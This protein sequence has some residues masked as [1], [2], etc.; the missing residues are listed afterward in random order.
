MITQFKILFGFFILNIVAFSAMNATTGAGE[1]LIPGVQYAQGIEATANLTQTEQQF[2]ATAMIDEW[3][4]S[5]EIGIPLFGDIYFVAISFAKK[6]RFLFDG[7]AMTLEWFGGFIPSTGG[8]A[9]LSFITLIIRGALAVMVGTLI[10]E[11][12]SGRRL[13]P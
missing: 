3:D 7:F 5:P 4:T 11:I 8:Q 9:A 6:M 12:I 13:M 10:F 2:N 1:P